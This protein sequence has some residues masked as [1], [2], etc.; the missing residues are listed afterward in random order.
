MMNRL[1]S[2]L[3]N[4][5]LGVRP[6]VWTIALAVGVVMMGPALG[7]GA[8]LNLDLLA[9]ATADLPRGTW[10]LGPELPRRV[11]L[12]T[13]LAP[14]NTVF[15][16]ETVTKVLLV[17]IIVAAFVG[18]FRLTRSAMEQ[19][20]PTAGGDPFDRTLLCLGGAMLWATGPFLM[21]RLA[22]GHWQISLATAAL[23]WVLPMLIQSIRSTRS[24]FLGSAV[25][26]VCGPYGAMLS[27]GYLL[28]TFLRRGSSDSTSASRLRCAIVWLGAQSIWLVPS[29]FV[30]LGTEG[31]RL[32]DSSAFPTDASGPL[33]VIRL[34]I[35]TGFW[36]PPFQVNA[37]GRVLSAV[38][39]LVLLML[40][41]IG[42]QALPSF[43]RLPLLVPAVASLVLALASCTP[44]MESAFSRFTSTPLGNL[45]R[46]PQ[47]FLPPLLLW[48]TLAA[49]VG[50]M[51]ICE[52]LRT[53]TENDGKDRRRAGV[54]GSLA[55]TPLVVALL[56]AAPAIWGL[57]GQLRPVDLP[58]EWA[59]ARSAI[60]GSPGTVLALPWF[61][62][63]TADIAGN[64]LIQNPLSSFLDGE[65][66]RSSDLRISPEPSRES[67]DPRESAA[68]SIVERLRSGEAQSSALA[69]LGV[70]WVAVAHDVD[71]LT[72]SGLRVDPGLEVAVEGPT[73]TLYRVDEVGNGTIAESGEVDV[74]QPHLLPYWTASTTESITMPMP[75]QFGWLRGLSPGRIG[76]DGRLD[77]PAGEGPIWFWPALV[78]LAADIAWLLAV[79]IAVRR[80]DEPPVRGRRADGSDPIPV[81]DPG[82]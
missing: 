42:T 32:A 19:S 7:P 6:W 3:R 5:I 41:I 79:V 76:P 33:D 59:E 44:A 60:H 80:P 56:L 51:R 49:T 38:L 69:E 20:S 73:L 36:N 9:F 15:G 68:A 2:I 12:G 29:A 63:F 14:L 22:V 18:A 54:A 62:Y 24:V 82:G 31:R 75:Y 70:R 52:R 39:A 61:A 26:A 1:R 50:A 77:L 48:I 72:Y 13:L 81:P 16:G 46:E 30:L 45:V 4:N 40:A 11:P 65:V 78:V 37:D 10:G 34:A 25:M 64:R 66:I 23:P 74:A 43:W 8:L 67:A 55:A 28:A 57:G 71:W 58:T 35:G 27:G 17:V 47:R 21:T 53:T